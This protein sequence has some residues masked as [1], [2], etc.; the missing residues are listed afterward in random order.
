[1]PYVR[2]PD[3]NQTS[4]PQDAATIRVMS[5]DQ[6]DEMERKQAEA[7]RKQ[8]QPEILGLVQFIE[9][10]WEENYN[11][12]REQN[13][14]EQMLFSLLQRNA[15]YDDAKFAE[16]ERM[17]G[18]QVYISLTGVKCRAA[19]SWL[20]DV[21]GSAG[22]KPW[23]LEATPIPELP[24]DVTKR[25][26]DVAFQKWS[27]KTMK[28]EGPSNPNEAGDMAMKLREALDSH[29]LKEAHIRA[30]R[31]EV[32][33]S[34]Q[35][36]E[37]D[38]EKQFDEFLTSLVT[39]KAGIMKGP[40]IR[41]R[42]KLK[43]VRKNG[44]ITAEKTYELIPV[45][46]SVSPFDIYPSPDCTHPN[47]GNL[48]E[49]IRLRRKDLHEMIGVEGYDDNAINLALGK[50]G[51]SG[52]SREID[53]DWERAE[54]EERDEDEEGHYSQT[55]EGL[56][57][58]GSVQGLML[59]RHGLLE[60]DKGKP[61]DPLGE[62]EMNILLVGRY[63]VYVA[64]NPDPLGRRPYSVTVWEKQPGSF[65]G[66]GVC[67]LMQ[68]IQNIC[69]AA[70]RALVNNLGISSGPQIVIND[71]N[72][73]PPGEDIEALS[74]WKI[75]Q[76]QNPMNS[77]VPGIDFFQPNS[78]AGELLT[79]YDKF[80]TLADEYT[81]IPSYISGDISVTGAGRTSQ[82]L[83]MLMNSAAKG[84]KKVISRIGR[85]VVHD[86]VRR[87]YEWNMMYDEDDSI[88][89]DCKI[90]AVGILGLIM[91]DQLLGRRIQFLDM[92]GRNPLDMEVVGKQQRAN[93]WREIATSLDMPKDSAVKTDQELAQDEMQKMAV[94]R[95]M[96]QVTP[97]GDLGPEAQG[98]GQR[99]PELS[100][101]PLPAPQPV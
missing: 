31:M 7:E 16:I 61:I 28:E 15:E 42:K 58:W 91:Q 23:Q 60:D 37:G 4:Y 48:L 50:Y 12:K 27:E 9:H 89:G 65:W 41:R 56:E 34:D 45:F 33:I 93:V 71:I 84:I 20:I 66:K 47:E 17:G 85:D 30:K 5:N 86:V 95:A 36:T 75:W 19:E 83:Q 82:G 68:D 100:P 49:R 46:K 22:D 10:T 29:M 3:P 39:F 32:K 51:I 101:S 35:F 97:G 55:I 80:S 54:L 74:P 25:I 8:Q 92:T 88:K 2:T 52:Y 87:M 44:K 53:T 77:T 63:I 81:G 78:N 40:V 26:A 94:Q 70:C 18:S 59:L 43:W 64:F 1:M 98:P 90:E 38:W 11:H 72:R 21:L 57:Y 79:V 69:N 76:L 67:E 13:I 24:E 14:D 73:L 99:P 6:I 62:Y 96:A